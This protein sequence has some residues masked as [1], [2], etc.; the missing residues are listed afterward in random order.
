MLDADA[1]RADLAERIVRDGVLVTAQVWSDFVEALRGSPGMHWDEIDECL[2][3]LGRYVGTQPVTGDT[4]AAARALARQGGF[5][6]PSALLMSAAREAGCERLY[7]SRL[8]GGTVGALTIVDPFAAPGGAGAPPAVR[9]KTPRERLAL[10]YARPGFLLRRAHQISASIFESACGGVGIT[11]GQLS[12]LAVLNARPGLDQ[13]TLARAIGL[14]KVTTSHLARALEGRG[15]LTRT[16]A[17]SRRGKS[18]QLTD[19]GIELL[20]RVDPCLDRAY[21]TLM[22]ALDSREQRQLLVLLG[23]LNTRLED[24]ARTPFHPL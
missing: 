20:D 3:T 4:L 5:D 9:R 16:A 8:P 21:D 17:D 2:D 7:S 14:D 11:P 19:E 15:L 10:L 24:R 12:V 13:A 22:S 1:G 23:R 6:F 18:M